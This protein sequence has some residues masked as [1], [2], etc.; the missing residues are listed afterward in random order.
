MVIY[1]NVNRLSGGII[2]SK[3]KDCKICDMSTFRM[4]F[5]IINYCQN[6]ANDG[7]MAITAIP[8]PERYILEERDGKRGYWDKLDKC[9]IPKEVCQKIAKNM[10]N[11]PIIAPASKIE[12]LNKYFSEKF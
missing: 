8:N 9:F 6:P 10:M 1:F 7:C 4:D 3:N 5:S 11:L 2:L 12:D